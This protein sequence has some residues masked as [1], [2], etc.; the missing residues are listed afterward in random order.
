MLT[1]QPNWLIQ[2]AQLTPERIALIFENKQMTFRELYHASKQMAARLS[3]YCSLKKGDRAAI[4]LSNRPEMVYAVHACFLLGAEA[5]LLNTKL[6]KQERLFQLEDS[7]AKLLLT[8]D[9]FCR[10]EY[11]SAVA[12]A[13]VD[14]LQAEEAGDMEPEA[15][16]TLDDTA[17]LMYTSGTTGRPKGVQQTFGNH[18]SSAVSSALN[19]GVTERDRWLIAL[20]LF[21]ISGLSAL[22]KSVIY[23]MPV[24][25]HQN[26]L[27]LMCWTAS[28]PIR[29]RSFQRCRPCSRACLRKLN[30][31]LNHCAAFCLAGVRHRCRSLKN[32]AGN[33]FRYSNL[34]A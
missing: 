20:P 7:Q 13:D 31:V 23:G 6:S 29:S 12:T 17:T 14:E 4:L 8:E 24:V 34:T 30:N 18:Y 33:N 10:E 2:R 22:F 5:V 15:Y 19:L 1:E 21:H 28:A 27:S 3:K 26:S 9:G 11:E 16:V 25:L 32:A